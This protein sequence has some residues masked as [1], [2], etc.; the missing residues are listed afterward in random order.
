MRRIHEVPKGVHTLIY[1][2]LMQKLLRY[3]K[4][5]TYQLTAQKERNTGLLSINKQLELVYCVK[6]G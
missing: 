4:F 6:T 3:N 5:K 2:I 1:F